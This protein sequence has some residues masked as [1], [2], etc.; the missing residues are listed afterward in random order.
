MNKR[1]NKN[2]NGFIISLLITL[3]LGGIYYYIFYPALNI[4]NMEFWFFL[5]MLVVVFYICYSIFN[6][7]LTLEEL[8]NRKK[9]ITNKFNYI[10]FVLVIPVVIVLI[11]IINL[12]LSPIFQ[13]KSYYKRISVDETAD[14]TTEI[15]EAD[16]NKM[17]LL[18]RDSSEK[19]GDRVM[20]QMPEL[21]SQFDVSDDYTQINY[22]DE[23]EWYCD[24]YPMGV[25]DSL[26]IIKE[27]DQYRLVFERHDDKVGEDSNDLS[28]RICNS[29]SRYLPFNSCFMNLYHNL[30]KIDPEN[31]QMHLEE[32]IYKQ[33]VKK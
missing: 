1:K 22:N 10:K 30:Q 28:I 24:N 9:I 15:K 8:F 21:V 26:K 29:G 16:F 32:Y 7:G 11:I 3:I 4:H 2:I 20:G 17:P 14:F 33:K 18:D 19:L 27:E 13:S 5:L 25:G 6:V 23:I 31:Y 12:F